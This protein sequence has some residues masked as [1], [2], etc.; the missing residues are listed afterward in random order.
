LPRTILIA[1]SSGSVSKA[2]LFSCRMRSSLT[3]SRVFMS[4]IEPMRRKVALSSV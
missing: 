1:W 3:F 4:T 2:T